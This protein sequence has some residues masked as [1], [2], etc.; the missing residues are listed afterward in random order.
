MSSP[1]TIQN[2]HA[3]DFELSVPRNAVESTAR[4]LF[5]PVQFL[6]F[7]TAVAL[8]F[9][10]PPLLYHGYVS[11]TTVTFALLLA[12]NMVAI[13]VGHGYNLD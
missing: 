1:P 13:V 9:A 7:W 10:Y 11:A 12:L 8:P 4:K 3:S 2:D 5:A 6:S